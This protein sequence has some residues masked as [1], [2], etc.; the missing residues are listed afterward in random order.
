M[1]L[2]DRLDKELEPDLI[3]PFS[4]SQKRAEQL[5]RDRFC[6]GWFVPDEIKHFQI[7]KILR[8]ICTSLARIISCKK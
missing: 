4:I 6:K 8:N 5:I 7:D 1:I 2:V 3:I